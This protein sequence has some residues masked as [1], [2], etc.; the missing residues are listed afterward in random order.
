MTHT[1]VNITNRRRVKFKFSPKNIF[2]APPGWCFTGLDYK[3][4]E[5]MI[6]A[7]V[8]DDPKMLQAFTE[9]EI[10]THPVTGEKID[11]PAADL[12]T[13]TTREAAFPEIFKGKEW[14][15]WIPT[16]KTKGLIPYPHEPRHYGKITNFTLIFGGTASSLAVSM[17]LPEAMG[18]KIIKGHQKTYQVYHAWAK[19]KGLI[20]EAT[21]WIATPWLHR[22]RAVHEENSK[23]AGSAKLLAP[24]VCIQGTG[25][26]IAKRAMVR[27]YQWKEKFNHPIDFKTM[28][29]IQAGQVH[30]EIVPIVRGDCRLNE[31]ACKWDGDTIV[32]PAWT[33]TGPVW[34]LAPQIRQIMI[35][36]ETEAFDGKLTGRVDDP[37][38]SPYWSK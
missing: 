2:M 24:N 18:A 23:G 10:V 25:A 37:N 32:K 30:D 17:A 13:I 33:V 5:L 27:I 12:H 16:A 9:P 34:D 4:Q 14:Y 38:P 8:S 22:V 11:N 20:G 1:P 31:E 6:A 36:V 35:D 3:S 19:E 26:N 28:S 29:V 15:E 21:G 7:V